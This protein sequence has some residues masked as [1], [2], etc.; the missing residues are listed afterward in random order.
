MVNDGSL[1]SNP[2][3]RDVEV[4]PVNDAPTLSSIEGLPASYIENGVPTGITGNLSVDDVDNTQIESATVTISNY[5]ANEDILSV[6]EQFG[7]T[8]NYASGVLSL[9]GSASLAQYEAVIHSVAYTN[10]SDDPSAATRTVEIVVNDGDSDSAPVF[11]DVEVNPVNDAPVVSG[12]E[13]S[14]RSYPENSGPAAISS[15]VSLLDVDDVNLDSAVVKITGN[16]TA[17]EDILSLSGSHGV[18]SSWDPLTGTLTIFGSDTV[19]N[20]QAALRSVTYENMSVNPESSPR[21]VSFSVSDGD[22]VSNIQTRDIGIDLV[23]NV[24]VLTSIEGQPAS[25][26]ENTTPIAITGNLSVGDVD[27]VLIQS[28]EVSISTNYVAAEDQLLFTDQSGITGTFSGGVLSLSGAAT[29]AEYEAAIHSVTYDNNS[30]N[31][32]V[33]VRTIQIVVNDGNAE[34][35]ALFRDVEVIPVNDAPDLTTIEGLPA[36]YLE[37][38]V[39]TG[40][41]GNLS[42]DCLLYTSPSPRD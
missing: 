13:T 29:I 25:Y 24:P 15:M 32:T 36:S 1:D 2:I 26:I 19:A 21:T 35:N 38:G 5:V 37:N 18:T 20:Y 7:I 30:E 40:I 39:P 3:S 22:A 12:I 14:L 42:V 11:R 33:A 34:S 4:V 9:S 41:T 27:D 6:V 17:G 31:P 23:N 10:L 8:G 16:Y 28:A